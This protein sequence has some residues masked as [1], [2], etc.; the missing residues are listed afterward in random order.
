MIKSDLI[1]TVIHFLKN[2]GIVTR[3]E[4]NVGLCL[5]SYSEL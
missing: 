4:E 3:K 2:Y 5:L 1:L